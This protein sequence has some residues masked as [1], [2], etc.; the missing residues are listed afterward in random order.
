[1]PVPKKNYRGPLNVNGAYGKDTKDSDSSRSWQGRPPITIPWPF[2]AECLHVA[3][4]K[5]RYDRESYHCHCIQDPLCWGP[6]G[7]SLDATGEATVSSSAKD[8][9]AANRQ[10][11]WRCRTKRIQ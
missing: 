6:R 5:K 1:M 10:R 2:L 4:K 3:H 11:K 9:V 8:R 7:L